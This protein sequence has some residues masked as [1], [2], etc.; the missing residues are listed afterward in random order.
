MN[1][2]SC[3]ALLLLQLALALTLVSQTSAWVPLPYFHMSYKSS[4]SSLSS[5]RGA[6]E[7]DDVAHAHRIMWKQHSRKRQ[8]M[9]YRIIAAEGCEAMAKSMESEHPD[10]FTYHPTKWGKFPDGTDNIEVG[11]F[12]PFN[13]LSGEHVLFLAS[14]HNNDVTLSQFQVIICLLQSFIESLTI[15]LPYYPVGTMERVTKEGTVATAATYAHMFSS[16]PSCGRPTRLMVYDLHTLQNRFYLERIRN[17]S[18]DCVAFPDDGAA[19]RFSALFMSDME[20]V[21]CGKTRGLGDERSVVIQHGDARGKNIVIVDDLVQT[22]GTLYECGQT[23]LEAGALSVNAYVSHAVFPKESWR[24]FNVGGD[25]AC[26]DKF[27][28]TNS[29]PPVANSLPVQDGIFEILDLR[30]IIIDDLDH[31]SSA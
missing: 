13:L 20:I 15:V 29:I 21:V 9:Q 19:K 5:S 28:V 26:F 22:G 6:D 11:G 1:P 24:R 2:P 25:R 16:L 30:A 8:S 12:L 17:S 4:S 14:F 18:I 27:W 10:R 3:I 7:N 31:F 23:L